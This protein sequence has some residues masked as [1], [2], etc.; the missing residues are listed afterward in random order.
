[1]KHRRTIF[2]ASVGLVRILQKVR[3]DTLCQI[4]VFLHPVGSAGQLVH[5]DVS[6]S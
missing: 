3:Q 2:H 1:M 5:S 6:G 4:C